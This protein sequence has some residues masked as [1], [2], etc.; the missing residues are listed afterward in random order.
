MSKDA[1]YSGIGSLCLYLSRS[2][3][4]DSAV[5]PSLGNLW[6][7]WNKDEHGDNARTLSLLVRL[8]EHG[9]FLF[10][11]FLDFRHFAYD[12][13]FVFVNYAVI[14]GVFWVFSQETETLLAKVLL[15]HRLGRR[16]AAE[17]G[18]GDNASALSLGSSPR[19]RLL[20]HVS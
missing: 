1:G 20:T 2:S 18:T 8:T 17:R 3:N 9:F 10:F 11:F 5:A 16:V 4:C 6:R 12:T 13:P 19:G 7:F 14:R 15:R